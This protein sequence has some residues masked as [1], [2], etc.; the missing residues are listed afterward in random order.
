MK[1]LP[2]FAMFYTLRSQV[3]PVEDDLPLSFPRPPWCGAALAAAL[4]VFVALG[5]YYAGHWASVDEFVLAIDHSEQLFQDFLDYYYPM[6]LSIYEA[7]APVRGYFYSAFFAILLTPLKGLNPMA[8]LWAWGAVQVVLLLALFA[9]PLRRLLPMDWRATALYAFVFASSV[10]LLHNVKWGQVSVLLVLSVL[11]SF[12]AYQRGWRVLAG[13]CLAFA[14]AVKY[15]PIVFL[16]YFL[17]RRDARVVLSTVLAGLLF[18]VITPT[19]LMEPQSWLAFELATKK[20]LSDASDAGLA[21]RDVNSQYVAHVLM[22]WLQGAGMDVRPLHLQLGAALGYAVFLFNMLL[23]LALQHAQLRC[24]LLL[25]LVLMFVSLPFV[26]KTSWP[27]YF[28]YLPFCQITLFMLTRQVQG[29]VAWRQAVGLGLVL[30]SVAMSNFF[31]FDL[32]ADWRAF[33]QWGLLFGANTLLM[34]ALYLQVLGS[35]RQAR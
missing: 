10:P 13:T 26:I 34:L 3:S 29:G 35:W 24:R 19:V 23:V 16:V 21:L 31:V 4:S 18:F 9:I 28:A 2:A 8:A 20:A 7:A 14:A 30:L 6:A 32:F 12:H 33:S 17:A 15:Y 22:R 27:H 25:S 5:F 11:A 1:A